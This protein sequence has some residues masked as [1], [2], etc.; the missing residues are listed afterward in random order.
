ME[1]DK[2]KITSV[3]NIVV[4]ISGCVLGLLLLVHEGLQRVIQCIHEVGV[5]NWGL[6]SCKF[7]IF[8]SSR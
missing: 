1:I 3:Y 5:V 6:H 2:I 8:M 4:V 7:K